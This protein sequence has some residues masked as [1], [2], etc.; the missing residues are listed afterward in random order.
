MEVELVMAEFGPNR[1]NAGS[2]ELPE[3]RLSPTLPT[4]LKY[5]PNLKLTLYSDQNLI[6]ET[7]TVQESTLRFVKPIGKLHPRQNWRSSSYYKV[8]GLLAS[9]KE[10]AIA[11]DSDF[12]VCSGEAKRII[13]LTRRFG[14][15]VVSN[16]RYLVK[17]D[18][19]VGAD[20][21]RKF[22]ESGGY[23]FAVNCGVMSFNRSCSKARKFL[24]LYG[25]IRWKTGRGTV[26][27]WRAQWESGFEF[28]P[29]V[30]PPQWNVCEEHC[31]IGNEVIL[32]AGH[33]KIREYYKI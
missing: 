20:S 16:P 11:M 18:T 7:K 31:G 32:H 29:Y 8:F 3:K 28:Q 21:D 19:L 17:V 30:L 4:M 5:F 23:G 26:A 14:V 9:T 6:A 24:E 2:A 33:Q 13:S 25:K 1:R 15:C 12:F 10:V 27:F 22:D